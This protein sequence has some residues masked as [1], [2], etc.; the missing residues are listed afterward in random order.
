[1]VGVVAGVATTAPHRYG[2]AEEVHGCDAWVVC[3]M[4]GC[5]WKG[6]PTHQ[7]NQSNIK[8]QGADPNELRVRT[9]V[10]WAL[11]GGPAIASRVEA[12]ATR[13]ATRPSR[14]RPSL[15]GSTRVENIRKHGFCGS[16]AQLQ[17][18]RVGSSSR[19]YMFT[20]FMLLPVLLL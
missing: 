1:M 5:L 17:P 6:S 4:V 9:S 15:L 8:R 18:G 19:L 10:L 14:W 7:A 11:R 3:C 2:L 12:I 16:A 20:R 13:V